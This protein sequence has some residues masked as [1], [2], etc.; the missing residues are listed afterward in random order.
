LTPDLRQQL[1]VPSSVPN[2]KSVLLLMWREWRRELSGCDAEP[3]IVPASCF[4]EGRAR[5][6]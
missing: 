3:G 6:V 2:G 5:S 4:E 1:N